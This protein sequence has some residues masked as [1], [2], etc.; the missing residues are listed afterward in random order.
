MGRRRKLDPHKRGPHNPN[1][2]AEFILANRDKFYK[3]IVQGLTYD[4]IAP[5]LGVSRSWLFNIT[6]ADPRIKQIKEEARAER[7]ELVHNTLFQLAIGNYKTETRHSNTV[8]Q[9]NNQGDV[10]TSKTDE[11]NVV[12]HIND[13]NMR[14]LSIFIRNDNLAQSNEEARI[15]DSLDEDYE[16]EY[17]YVD[18]ADLPPEDGGDLGND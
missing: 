1:A 8:K 7:R 9:T 15:R 12:E 4:Q 5:K 10:I 6:N 3:W 17:T 14:A 2:N 11:T 16:D 13:P 18:V